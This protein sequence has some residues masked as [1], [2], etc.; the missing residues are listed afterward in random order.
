MKKCKRSRVGVSTIPRDRPQAEHPKHVWALDF[1]YDQT[2]DCR[3]LKHLNITDDLTTHPLVIEVERSM[4]GDDIA[5][6]LEHPDHD[7]RATI[8]RTDG[9]RHRDD[10]TSCRERVLTQSHR[11]RVNRPR[12]ALAERVRRIVHRPAAR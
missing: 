12:I 5:T 8:P 9:K 4:T 6:V 10:L 1:D 2:A 11:D 3:T 7:P